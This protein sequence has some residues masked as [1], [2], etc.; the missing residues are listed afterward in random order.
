MDPVT[1]CDS[2]LCA[3]FVN[4]NQVLLGDTKNQPQPKVKE[5]D[6]DTEDSGGEQN[7]VIDDPDDQD[8]LPPYKTIP[9]SSNSPQVTMQGAIALVNR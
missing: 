4:S 1:S 3:I 6:G 8:V 2:F 5:Y 7:I 9:S